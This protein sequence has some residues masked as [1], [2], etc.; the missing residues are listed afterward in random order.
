MHL[1]G[2]YDWFRRPL[3]EYEKWERQ[4]ARKK[5]RREEEERK[6]QAREEGWMQECREE[7]EKRR[8]VL[9]DQG[10]TLHKRQPQ[11]KGFHFYSDKV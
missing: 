3:T 5:L 1:K 11:L 4:H 6:R 8:Q 10:F 9:R 7:M 2:C